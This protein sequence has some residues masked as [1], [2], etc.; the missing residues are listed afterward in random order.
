MFSGEISALHL[1]CITNPLKTVLYENISGAVICNIFNNKIMMFF[2]LVITSTFPEARTSDH[3]EF[4]KNLLF[5]VKSLL[6][7]VAGVLQDIRKH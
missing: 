5:L 3:V 6:Q 1:K 7:H 4:S 2:G